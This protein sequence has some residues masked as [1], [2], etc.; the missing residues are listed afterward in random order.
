VES[1]GEFNDHSLDETLRR[2][3]EVATNGVGIPATDSQ[4]DAGARVQRLPHE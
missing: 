4:L 2:K 3:W 1:E